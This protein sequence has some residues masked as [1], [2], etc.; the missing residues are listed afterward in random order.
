M[1]DHPKENQQPTTLSGKVWI[2]REGFHPD[3]PFSKVLRKT[4]PI[5]WVNGKVCEAKYKDE[6]LIGYTLQHKD[7]LLDDSSIPAY[8]SYTLYT[9]RVAQGHG[10]PSPL[11]RTQEPVKPIKLKQRAPGFEA[12]STLR[13]VIRFQRCSDQE[14]LIVKSLWHDVNDREGFKRCIGGWAQQTKDSV[15]KAIRSKVKEF[16]DEPWWLEGVSRN[17]QAL[18]IRDYFLKLLRGIGSFQ[19][20]WRWTKYPQQRHIK[21][22]WY[23]IIETALNHE[24][25]VKRLLKICTEQEDRIRQLEYGGVNL[26][27]RD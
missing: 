13:S 20:Q 10:W 25:M 9:D 22:T 14:D 1:S 16:L 27:N 21:E 4:V 23:H 24:Y 2:D 11:D 7:L 18:Q 3:F 26:D 12:E 19:D 6:F 8:L 15:D 5:T 17:N